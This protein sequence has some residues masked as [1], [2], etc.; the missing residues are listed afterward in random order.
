[1]RVVISFALAGLVAYLG[2]TAMTWADKPPPDV[3]KGLG[4]RVELPDGGTW[5]LA[6]G[7]IGR[8]FAVRFVLSNRGEAAI[9]L[10]DADGSEGRGCFHVILTDTKGNET[11]LQ[12][13]PVERSAGVPTAM[14]LNPGQKL[15]INF[16]LLR[17][18]GEKSP[19]AGDYQLRLEYR[20]EL[21]QAGPVKQVWTGQ[22]ASASKPLK[23]VPPTK[24]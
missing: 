10:W 24:K 14:T 2:W 3:D 19:A 18:I 1:M 6:E 17:L 8:P 22:I 21:A 15:P 13:E 4:L 16:D 7:G 23:I 11:L 20:N 12:P 9:T 5:I